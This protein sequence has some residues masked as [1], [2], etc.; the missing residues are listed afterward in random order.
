[1]D[2]IDIKIIELLK[3]N[4]R[5]SGSD[6]SKEVH[7]SVPV[8]TERI[9]KLEE[10]NVIEQFTVKLNREKFGLNLAAFIFVTLKDPKY[11]DNFKKTVMKFDSVLEC[12]HIAGEYDYLLKVVVENTKALERFVSYILKK[13]EGVSRTNTI[14]TMSS[15]KETF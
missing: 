1:M 11:I 5:L 2:D 6:I 15:I 14:I 9:R 7:L 13:T 10:G 4:S 8:V 3:K 12:H